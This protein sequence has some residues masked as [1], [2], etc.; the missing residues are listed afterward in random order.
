MSS[1]FEMR[2]NA[3]DNN[4]SP[5][6]HPVWLFAALGIWLVILALAMWRYHGP[7]LVTATDPQNSMVYSGANAEKILFE[8]VGNGVPHPAGSKDNVRV[9]ELI[10]GKVRGLGFDVYQQKTESHIHLAP[11]NPEV[12]LTNI[13]FRLEGTNSNDS[14]AVMLVAHYDSSRNGPGAGDDGVGVASVLEIARMLKSQPALRNDVIFLLTDGEEYGL[15]GAAR[16]CEEHAW[17]K[18]V[19]VCINLEARGTSGPSL[20]F[21]TSE[22]NEWLWPITT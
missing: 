4:T 13:L 5:T 19:R 17:A 16:F 10:L 7:Q 8:L 1:I 12:E 15:L 2:R 22:G 14:P 9:R 11:A 21:Q 6:T 3:I 18:Q 20:M